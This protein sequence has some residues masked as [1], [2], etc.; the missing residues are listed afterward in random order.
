MELLGITIR[1][2]SDTDPNFKAS[3]C[4]VT[5]MVYHKQYEEIV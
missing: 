1:F 3:S 2:D 4:G 5:A